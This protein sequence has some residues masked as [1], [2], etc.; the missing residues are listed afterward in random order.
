MTIAKPDQLA[1]AEIPTAPVGEPRFPPAFYAWCV[2]ALLTVAYAL[3]LLDR[4]VLTLL[5]SP[6][7][8]ALGASDTAIGLL[9]GPIFALVYVFLGL[10]FGW[11]ADRYNRRN[12]AAAGIAFWCLMT[13]LSG[14]ATSFGLLALCRFGIGFGEAALTPAATSIIG[15]I[16]P[17]RRV[18][19]A[20]GVFNLGIYSGMGL[21]Y[22]IG[23][24]LLGWAGAHTGSFIGGGWQTWQIVFMAV[25]APGFPVA[26][27]LLVLVREPARRGRPSRE[28]VSMRACLAHVRRHRAALV[29]LA[30]GMG[31]V[32]LS[33]Y[34]FTWLPAMF[35]RVWHWQPQQFSFV[36]GA[37][38]IVVG[39]AGAVT[40]GLL[41]DRFY[42]AG[43]KEGP[44]RVIQFGLPVLVLVGGT[45]SLW[46]SPTLVLTALGIAAFASAMS[47]SAGVAAVIFATPPHFRGRM[48]ALYTMTNSSIGT[49]LGPTAVGL[50]TDHV[51][52]TGDGIRYALATVLL[53][54]GGS[55]A[56]YLYTARRSYIATV[57]ELDASAP[58]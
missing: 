17:R 22:L 1:V 20:V 37:I 23:G 35:T 40:A 56:A 18:S 7:K 45:A 52:G 28:A 13:V 43:V 48:M 6:L 9:L 29:P 19:S 30:V 57:A 5:V 50:L 10:P 53:A 55:L 16:F 44:F 58:A 47:T 41:A 27:L 42:R 26:L 12:L 31:T 2:V 8:A 39:P 4:W 15:D 24:A 38:L 46:P 14:L 51:F 54:V 36:Y 32:A 3:S 33:G 21:S 34:S 25:G 11:I 49:I